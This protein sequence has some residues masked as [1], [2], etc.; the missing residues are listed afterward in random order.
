MA[1]YYCHIIA[2]LMDA[3][4]VTA[5]ADATLL[6]GCLRLMRCIPLRHCHLY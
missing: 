3:I 2:L 6:D 5:G 4:T 1:I